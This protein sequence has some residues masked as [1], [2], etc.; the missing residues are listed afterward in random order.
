[1]LPDDLTDDRE[2]RLR[3]ERAEQDRAEEERAELLLNT[4][5]ELS[6]DEVDAI[7]SEVWPNEDSTQRAFASVRQAEAL[8]DKEQR[9]RPSQL[10]SASVQLS[11]MDLG[12]AKT[13]PATPRILLIDQDACRLMERRKLLSELKVE[14]TVATSAA[15][16][17]AVLE[18][19]EFQLVI[20]DYHP[21]T[22]E[23]SGYLLEVQEF[24]LRVPVINVQAWAGLIKRDNRRLNRDLL[25]A[26]A[27]VLRKPVPRRLPMKRSPAST[28]TLDIE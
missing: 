14:T 2:E 12:L 8:C 15:D 20:V 22:A 27:G 28:L 19:A 5:M 26:V 24:N 13:E 1:M 7:Y 3:K 25:R 16:A 18:A 21:I 11:Q 6:Q 10:Q 9:R 23:D 17:V 4:V